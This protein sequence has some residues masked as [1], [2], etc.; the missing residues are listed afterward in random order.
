[1][2]TRDFKELRGLTIAELQQKAKET[3]EELFNLRFALRTGHLS[4]FSKVR[5]MRRTYAQ[6]QTVICEKRIAEAKNGAA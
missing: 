2:N 3:K 1:M 4:D 5:A 6:I